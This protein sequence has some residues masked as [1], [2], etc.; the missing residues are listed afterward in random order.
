MVGGHLTC[1]HK[2]VLNIQSQTH[3]THCH[4]LVPSAR[5]C[6]S[7]KFRQRRSRTCGGEGK[8]NSPGRVALN[9]FPFWFEHT[10]SA[11]TPTYSSQTCSTMETTRA[12]TFCCVTDSDY[13][14]LHVKERKRTRKKRTFL[15]HSTLIWEPATVLP[16]FCW[17]RQVEARGFLFL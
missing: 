8:S 14:Y 1:Q 15:T 10:V 7:T 11:P 4:N 3:L 17:V 2:H 9:K 6:W 5:R 13:D 12:E 16:F